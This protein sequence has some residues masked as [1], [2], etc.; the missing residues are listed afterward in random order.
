MGQ[1]HHTR[2]RTRCT[3]RPG[4]GQDGEMVSDEARHDDWGS[5][6]HA[7]GKAAAPLMEIAQPL[8]NSCIP[9]RCLTACRPAASYAGRYDDT[10]YTEWTAPG[11]SA[12][13]NA[14]S[15]PTRVV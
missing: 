2:S 8:S 12:G 13:R 11:K 5:R 9:V 15:K 14:P 3:E 6:G 1:I 10:N 4:Q 7:A